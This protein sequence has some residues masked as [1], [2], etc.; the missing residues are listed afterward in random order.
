MTSSS[1]RLESSAEAILAALAGVL[2]DVEPEVPVGQ[3]DERLTR[4]A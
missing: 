3:E 2:H 1:R 4:V